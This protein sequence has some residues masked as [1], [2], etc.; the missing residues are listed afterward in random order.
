[1]GIDRFFE[2]LVKTDFRLTFELKVNFAETG[3]QFRAEP[4]AGN[5]VAVDLRGGCPAGNPDA[6]SDWCGKFRIAFHI[7]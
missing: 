2:F 7:S 4:V 5:G 6:E 3:F 1:M